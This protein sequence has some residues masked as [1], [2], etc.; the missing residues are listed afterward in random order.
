M[1]KLYEDFDGTAVLSLRVGGP[2][3]R[4]LGPILNPNNLYIE[5]WHVADSRS[6]EQL[7][8][9]SKDVRDLLPQGLAIDDF[10]VLAA[11]EDLVRLQEILKLN[12]SL[13]G[14][15]VIS[16]SGRNYGKISD[17][18]FE[19]TNFFVQKLY[20]SQ[21]VIRNFAGGTL[22]IDRSQ[23]IEITNRR[24]IIEDPTEKINSKVPAAAPVS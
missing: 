8:L 15:K 10:E 18:A 24:V 11:E 3:A 4:V 23:I 9:L 20:V 16:Q 12:F 2:V 6:G 13:H 19:T 1:L 5:G 14:L 7:V 17:F 22:S 21:P